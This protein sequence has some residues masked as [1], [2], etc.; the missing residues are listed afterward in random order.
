LVF[1]EDRKLQNTPEVN[2]VDAAF[3]YYYTSRLDYTQMKNLK[4]LQL[5]SVG[6]DHIPKEV[7]RDRG[8]YL[9]NNS[10]GYSVPIAEFA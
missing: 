9:A 1:V 2:E 7:F 3:V 4:F 10:G 5:A 6:F 8:I